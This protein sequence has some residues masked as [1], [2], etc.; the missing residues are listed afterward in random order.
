MDLSGLTADRAVTVP[1]AAMAFAQDAG[2]TASQV[3][4][5]FEVTTAL[6]TCAQVDLA[7]DVT[8]NLPVTNLNGGTGAS[9]STFW[10]GDGTWA[11]PAGGGSITVEEADGAP[12][13]A[14]VTTAQFDQVDG[15]TVT[16]EGGGQVQI[17]LVNAPDAA[18]ADNITLTAIT[19]IT[20]RAITDLTGV[21]NYSQL[22]G[23]LASPGTDDRVLIANGTNW[24]ATAITG[25]S[26]TNQGNI[27]YS[28]SANTLG[29]VTVPVGG[30]GTGRITLT[31]GA[32]LLGNGTSAV[33]MLGPP[34]N[35]QLPIGNGTGATLATLSAEAGNEIS[36]TNGAGSI[37]LDVNEANLDLAV[38]GGTLGTGQADGDF[39]LASE[40]NAGTNVTT[41]L[42]EEGQ[43]N[44]TVVTG[45]A[46]DDQLLLGSGANAAA[47]ATVPD[48]DTPT[49]SKLLYDQATNTFSCGTDQDTG[50]GSSVEAYEKTFSSSTSLSITNA[51]HGIG[52]AKVVWACYDNASPKSW[53]LPQSVTVN[54]STFQV[55][56][57]F[58]PATSGSCTVAG[59]GSANDAHALLSAQHN[60]TTAAAVSDD[61]VV[62]GSASAWEKKS[63]PDSD[64]ADQKLQ[65][66]Q[67]TNTFS[68]GTDD[69][70]PEAGDFGAA[71]DLD[72][73]GAIVADSVGTTELDDAADTPSTGELLAV[74]ATTTQVEYIAQ[75]TVAAGTAAALAANGGNCGAGQWAAGV[76]ANGVAEGCTA[77]DDVPE[78]GDFGNATD[79][80]SNG[81]VVTKLREDTK[82]ITLFDENNDITTTSDIPSF[83]M[84][85]MG[86]ITLTEIACESDTGTATINMQRDDGTP[87]N[88]LASDLT[89][90][91]GGATA[92]PAAAEDNVALGEEIDFLVQTSPAGTNRINACFTFTID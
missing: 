22:P 13:V 64:G 41:D 74:A 51:E 57:T 39:L 25:C 29:C 48:C 49:T 71:T 18:V 2:C 78:S 44:A 37:T 69:D 83:W 35:G 68:A 55:D 21:A 66:D 10:R 59:N 43:I 27:G 87:A 34:T 45:N 85:R 80:D 40:Q 79:L 24:V 16:D 89:C 53:I 60:D 33:T 28:T 62:V 23:G 52:H 38:I 26:T 3:V 11:T 32:F 73:N 36:I 56:F 42:E 5:D 84:N 54:T 67:A 4:H 88:I 91:T 81:S 9:S 7:A 63:L 77:D 82:C 72:A 19:Q 12:S 14:G 50:G 61:T 46:A 70:V 47:Y 6:F 90:S 17:D 58:N 20:N 30:G 75:S 65:Y 31:S 86:A 15:F 92:T 76:D 8:G 1:D